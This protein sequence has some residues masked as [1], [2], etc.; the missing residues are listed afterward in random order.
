MQ[1]PHDLLGEYRAQ[2]IDASGRLWVTRGYDVYYSDDFGETFTF[3]TRIE[4][5][6]LMNASSKW[7]ITTRLLRRGFLHLR[8]LDDGSL[9]GVV[10]GAVVRCEPHNDR[11]T[12]VFERPGRTMK[13]EV[14]P[15]GEIYAG[16]YFYNRERD[17]VLIFRSTDGGKT[18]DT[19]YR[20]PPGGIRHIHTLSFDKRC[21]RLIVLTGDTDDESKVLFTND[22]FHSVRI[23]AEGT[24]RS[25]AMAILATDGGYF[26][27]T[28]TPFEQ[29]YIQYLTFDGQLSVRCP[30]VGSCLGGCQVGDWSLFATATEPSLVNFN[31]SVL[32]YGTCNGSEWHVIHSWRVDRWSWPTTLQ[33]AAF[34]FG[35]I[36]MP[37]GENKTGYLFGTP[38]AIRKNDGQLHRW[39]LYETNGNGEAGAGVLAQ[40]QESAAR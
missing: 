38:V 35:R 10:Y 22:G 28:D 16:E 12:Q 2:V 14:L 17:E 32:M 29:N 13:L 15:S 9:L 23:L 33:A 24:Q 40:G 34:Q 31:P 19:A 20:F 7:D 3:R 27:P 21:G 26:L 18:W 39:K 1:F 4:T 11:F 8:P 37:S 25:R 36:I 30:I 6:W 5:K